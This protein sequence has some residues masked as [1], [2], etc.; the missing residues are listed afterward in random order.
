MQNLVQAYN[1]NK[2]LIQDFLRSY[3][4]QTKTMCKTLI[5]FT[6]IREKSFLNRII[7]NT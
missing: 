3:L 5:I 7:E 1:H 6:E 2:T 4:Q